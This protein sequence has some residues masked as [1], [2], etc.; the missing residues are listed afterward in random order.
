MIELDNIYNMDCLDGM[1]QI[2]SDSVDLTV[3][4]PP[5]DNLRTYNGYCFDFENIARELYRVTKQGGVVVWVVGDATIEGNETC[6]SFKQ[7][8]FFR[9]CGFKLLDTMIY[10]K[11]NYAPMYP[12]ARRYANQFE[13]MFIFSKGKHKTFNP[14][15]KSKARNRREVLA[16]RQKDGS[17]HRK[18][19]EAGRE[20]KD[21]SNV[22]E[23][24]VGGNSSKD[25]IAF[26]HPAIFPE[27]LAR[28]HITSWSNEGD[29][30]LDPF[31]GSGTTAKVA[32]A[33]N[34][35]YIGFEISAEYC[36]I[37]RK[38]LEQT[39]TLFDE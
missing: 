39:K 22:W 20:T 36:D 18:V 16:Y 34:R 28:D 13:Y 17:F 33:L 31:M 27:L 5:Y 3:T 8:L 12:S 21:A 38:R 11:A 24:S 30:V 7:A 2:A 14:I 19:K 25:D 10:L 32:R 9:E 35:H 1:R 6:T 15:Q 4:S 26:E 29:I 37:I 23:Y